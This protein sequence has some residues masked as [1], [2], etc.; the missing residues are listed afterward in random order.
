MSKCEDCTD[1]N[2]KPRT[3]EPLPTGAELAAPL[4]KP[5]QDSTDLLAACTCDNPIGGVKRYQCL[6]CIRTY[7]IAVGWERAMQE[8]KKHTPIA[9]DRI[10]QEAL[11]QKWFERIK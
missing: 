2:C 3:G 10:E 7:V 8:A 5:K 1:C 4:P 6:P 9:A 11:T